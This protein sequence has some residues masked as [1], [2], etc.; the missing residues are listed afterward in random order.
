MPQQVHRSTVSAGNGD[1]TVA[2]PCC[3]VHGSTGENGRYPH[4]L[5][6]RANRVGNAAWAR[7]KRGSGWWT[8]WRCVLV[9]FL[10]LG[11]FATFFVGWD[12]LTR[13]FLPSLSTAAR[14][15]LL[16]GWAALLTGIASATIYAVVHRQHQRLSN[17]A[18]RLARLID[19][20]Q[21]DPTN[22]GRFENP[23]LVH[24]R[25]ELGCERRECPMYNR[26]GER[27]WQVMALDRSVRDGVAPRIELELCLNCE[28]YRRS[29]PDKLTELG[30]SFNNLMFL[31]EAE[32]Q[33]FGRMQGELFEKEKM[34]AIGQLAAGIAH[35]VCNPLSSISAVVQVLK[36]E[37]VDA[38]VGERL[39]LIQTHIQ[40]ITD[41]VRKL[42]RLAHPGVDRWE[43]VDLKATLDE[44]VRLIA[45]DR[46]ARNVRIDWAPTD[47][48]LELHG[49]RDQ[50][51]QVF[52]NLALNAL[53]A[54][55]DGGEL[56]IRAEKQG[57]SIVV[58]LAD[59]GCGVPPELG[60]RIFDPFFTT[61]PQGKG[62]GLG[63]AVSYGVVQRHGGTIDFESNNGRGTV[64]TIELPIQATAADGRS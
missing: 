27:C 11:I 49:L 25:A 40:R 39:D 37:H 41:I 28:V 57:Q 64:F 20:C 1:G 22:A 52:I 36:R 53:D 18:E 4:Q 9:P 45:Y 55:P 60:R 17:T 24:C 43:P 54:M 38:A 26:P 42:M 12:V 19:A 59:T 21:T 6:Q 8:N 2:Q 50:L 33:R 3:G 31:L 5:E 29:C 51:Q 62:T 47:A 30:E 35:E 61:K 14:H 56:R 34:A 32:S 46:R 48:D 58:R 16:T 15:A 63:L 44:V 10:G 13:Y 7:S 23:H